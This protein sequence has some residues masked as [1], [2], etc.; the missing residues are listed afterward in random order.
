MREAP[1]RGARARDAA[2]PV[3][4]KHGVSS[5]GD[6]SEKRPLDCARARGGGGA[7]ARQNRAA[8]RRARARRPHLDNR[9]Q[10]ELVEETGLA[11]FVEE[12][13]ESAAAARVGGGAHE[14]AVPFE[15][16]SCHW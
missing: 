13:A 3:T 2:A 9:A 14:T 10:V 4:G 15:Y 11:H 12:L 5:A 16:T 7:S 1:A 6:V 8:T